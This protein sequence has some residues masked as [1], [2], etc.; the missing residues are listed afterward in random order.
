MLEAGALLPCC[1][2]EEWRLGDLRLLH[3]VTKQ[4]DFKVLNKGDPLFIFMHPHS[5]SCP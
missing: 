5:V 2:G 3:G 1:D 4:G